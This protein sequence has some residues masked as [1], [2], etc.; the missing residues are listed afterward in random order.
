MNARY[1]TRDMEKPRDNKRQIHLIDGGERVPPRSNGVCERNLSNR[2]EPNVAIFSS[3]LLGTSSERTKM[4]RHA[5][6]WLK[7]TAKLRIKV[8]SSRLSP[9]LREGH[10]V[11]S[12]FLFSCDPRGNSPLW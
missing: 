3:L 4:A 12:L 10:G 5:R 2:I 8:T 11:P 7:D 9:R 6:A 1:H